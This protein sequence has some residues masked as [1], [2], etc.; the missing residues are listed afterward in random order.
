M[1]KTQTQAGEQWLTREQAAE[2]LK[3]SIQTLYAL[4]ERGDLHPAHKKLGVGRGGRRVFYDAREIAELVPERSLLTTRQAAERIGVDTRTI[5][6]AVES[7][8]LRRIAPHIGR[9]ALFYPTDIDALVS[10]AVPRE[11]ARARKKARA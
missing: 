9:S 11:K 7:G 5:A 4:T 6:R 10:L 8:R 3:V 2:R 1:S